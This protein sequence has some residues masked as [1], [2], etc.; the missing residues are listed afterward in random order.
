[1][2][3]CCSHSLADTRIDL[4]MDVGRNPSH[5]LSDI[6]R[7]FSNNQSRDASWSVGGELYRRAQSRRRPQPRCQFRSL[8]WEIGQKSARPSRAILAYVLLKAGRLKQTRPK[9]HG[10]TSVITEPYL[11]AHTKR[12]L[13]LCRQVWGW[14]NRKSG[15]EVIFDRWIQVNQANSA[16]FEDNGTNSRT[17]ALLAKGPL[18]QDSTCK[19]IPQL[20]Q[21]AGSHIEDTAAGNSVRCRQSHSVKSKR[22]NLFVPAIVGCQVFAKEANA[23]CGLSRNI[24]ISGYCWCNTLSC[25]MVGL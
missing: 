9:V 15:V 5:Q 7:Q 3:R 23:G 24:E 12:T 6:A 21:H 10:K 13:Q 14:G 16:W 19:A 18:P 4:L 25:W 17:V 8:P 11:S 22:S 20:P 2:F 1:M